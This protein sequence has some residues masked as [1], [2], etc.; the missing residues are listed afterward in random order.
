MLGGKR[1]YRSG[2]KTRMDNQDYP[3]LFQVADRASTECQR[4]HLLLSKLKLVLLVAAA[5]LGGISVR[6]APGSTDWV[7]LTTAVVL[8]LS[9][10]VVSVARATRFE[11]GW[12]TC[13]VVAESA[14][15]CAW[16]YMMGASPYELTNP[17]AQTDAAFLAELTGLLSSQRGIERYMALYPVD[18]TQISPRMRDVRSLGV[19]DRLRRYLQERLRNQKGWYQAKAKENA[20]AEGS[21]FAAATIVQVLAVITAFILVATGP[22]GLSPI[23]ALTTLA[24]ALVAWSELK[25]H[26]ELAQSYSATVQELAS[27]EDLANHVRTYDELQSYVTQVEGAISREHTFWRHRRAS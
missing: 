27:L 3:I 19:E 6:H 26:Q 8:L 25:R 15:S 22:L 9:L 14:K 11:I 13:R 16:R 18:G 17:E 24:T 5:L 20:S 2:D 21:W 10:A 4:K 7:S 23:G 1:T 12:F